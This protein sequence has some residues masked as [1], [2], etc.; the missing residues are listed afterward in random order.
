V[1]AALRAHQD[2]PDGRGG[3]DGD[4]GDRPRDPRPVARVAHGG[5]LPRLE[6]LRGHVDEG[7]E[8]AL[9]ARL[10]LGRRLDRRERAAQHHLEVAELPEHGVV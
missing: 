7:A 2:E 10:E 3:A 1:P 4:G 5:E 9:Q 6:L 8:G